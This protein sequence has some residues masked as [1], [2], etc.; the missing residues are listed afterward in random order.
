MM[1]SS[2]QPVEAKMR[3]VGARMT[4]GNT[5]LCRERRVAFVIFASF[6]V[7][8]AVCGA[9]SSAPESAV[10]RGEELFRSKE[11]SRSR[12][13]DFTCATCHSEDPRT[14]GGI[15]T[16]APIG[17]VTQR[18]TYWGG[19]ENDLLRAVDDCR[20]Y[21]MSDNE[22]LTPTDRDAEAL[23]AYLSSL[24]PDL[25]AGC[26]ASPGCPDG[27]TGWCAAAERCLDPT[28][29]WPFTVVSEIS[30]LPRGDATSGSV[31]FLEACSNCHGLMHTGASRLSERVPVLPEDTLAAHSQ[32]TPRV[33]RLIFTEK[34]RHG[35]FLGYG[36]NMPPFSNEVLS[37]SQVSDLLEALGVLG[38]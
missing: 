32:F 34:I 12:L 22:P 35:L 23:Y 4:R 7:L 14:R 18:A 3:A 9:C 10:R 11:L 6:G 24:P 21:F 38:Q 27:A 37:D 26:P 13:N 16:G 15:L 2:H 19:Q 30:A 33:Q 28:S 31:L 5:T 17:G 36:G 25:T 20:N 8:A 1:S 29:P